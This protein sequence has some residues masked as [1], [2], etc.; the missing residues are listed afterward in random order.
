[1]TSRALVSCVL[2][3]R[4]RPFLA[5]QAVRYFQRQDY[6]FRELVIVDSGIE[7]VALPADHRIRRL[8]PDRPI[9][10][11]AARNLGNASA[12]GELL[13]H[14]DDDD[15]IGPDRLSKQVAALQRC[16]TAVC[17]G[18]GSLLYYRPAHAD[19]WRYQPLEQ[20]RAFLAGG[21][22]LYRREEWASHPFI[23]IDCGEDAAFVAGLGDERVLRLADEGWYV[24]LMHDRNTSAKDLGDS[25]WSAARLDEVA[26]RIGPDGA[27]YAAMRSGRL[28]ELAEAPRS[29]SVTVASDL[30]IYDG[31]GSMAEYAALGMARAGADVRLAPITLDRVGLRS[32]T[33]ALL[34]RSGREGPVLYWTTPRPALEAYAASPELFIRAVWESSRLPTDWLGRFERARAVIA[35][36]TYV[37]NVCRASG[38]TVPLAVIP[39]GVDPTVHHWQRR[40]ERA[41]V[42]TLI[43]GTLIP[44]KHLA[45][46]LAAWR[47]AFAGDANAR[48]LVKA[49]FQAGRLTV[50]DPRIRVVDDEQRTRGIADW[51]R[52]ADVL[53]AL[54]NEGFGLPLVEGM[55]CGLPVV[56]L[57]SEGQAD[58]CREAGDLV[59]QVPPSHLE[60]YRDPVYGPCGASAVPDVAVA[61]AQLRWVA[62]H[63]DEARELGRSAS[64]WATHHRNVWRMGPA[65]LD[66]LERHTAPA[67]TLRRRRTLWVPSWRSRCGIGEYTW[68]LLRELCGG[69]RVSAKPPEHRGLR[70]LHVQ[71]EDGLFDDAAL[72]GY[73]ERIDAPVVITEH[74]VGAVAKPWEERAAALVA[75]TSRGVTELRARA[76]GRPVAHLPHGCPEWFPP[77]KT[78]RGRVIGSFGFMERYKG[79]TALLEVLRTLPGTELVLYSYPKDPRFGREFEHAAAGLPVRWCRD[80]LPAEQVAHKLAAECDLLAFWYDEV[81]HA[82]AS[83]AARIGLASGV[84]VLTSR[85][86]WFEDLGHTTW[87]PEQL[88]QGVARLLEDGNLRNDLVAAAR[89]YCTKHS[90]RRIA[91]DHLTLWQSIERP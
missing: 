61:A 90:W 84:P 12:R 29:N 33:L 48:L 14:W 1:M 59:L 44:R 66:V 37:A 50:D 88:T 3:T 26:A 42:T 47:M 77:R 20:D 30:M 32:E 18:L 5:L 86:S 72:A 52:Q 91:A 22:L 83:G 11:G 67:R 36:S 34:E 64:A 7:P 71:H 73:L 15:W 8:R 85:T 4:D 31:L 80:Y 39:D 82:S 13:A 19:A 9:T 45:E 76:R 55:A 79:F 69:A 25:R 62:T 46:G 87:Q 58:V 70:L 54:G 63:R 51:Y 68:H 43:V 2:P 38:L 41:G 56:A 28:A 75:L 21:T 17:C 6:P 35:A 89:D 65:V 78:T 81:P 16:P 53:L 24:A 40:P 57:A 49:R 27:F 10:V 74:S 23:E 60:S